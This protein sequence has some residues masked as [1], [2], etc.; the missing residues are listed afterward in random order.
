MTQTY[1]H[2]CPVA[3]TLEKI[4]DKW[5]LL[6]IRDLLSGPQRF[7]DLLG[8][9]NHI[10]PKWLTQRLRELESSGIIERDKKPGRRQ[11]WYKL[12]PA[13]HDLSPIV[14]ALST[15]GFRYAMRPPIPGEVVHP[16]LLM[17]SLT[18][19]LNKKGKRLPRPAKWLMQFPQAQYSLSFNDENWSSCREEDP[20]SDLKINTTPEIWATIFTAPRSDRSRLAQAIQIDGAPDRIEEFQQTFGIQNQEVGPIHDSLDTSNKQKEQ[21]LLKEK[22]IK[23]K[24]AIETNPLE[25]E[26]P[27]Y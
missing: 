14:D 8:Y 9:L 19:S 25:A 13:G 11:V 22:K 5:S 1:G 21:G 18:S 4:G 6:I 15:W 23:L 20:N 12:T 3:R 16:D 24:Q 2:F 26:Q 17:R 10:T 27:N 7:T